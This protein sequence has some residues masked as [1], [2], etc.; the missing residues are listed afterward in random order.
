MDVQ[1]LLLKDTLSGRQYRMSGCFSKTASKIYKAFFEY[2]NTLER[3]YS[4]FLESED[5]KEELWNDDEVILVTRHL[6]PFLNDLKIDSI[7]LL[8]NPRKNC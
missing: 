4:D 6:K 1:S 7:N 8:M 5:G 3:G 2:F